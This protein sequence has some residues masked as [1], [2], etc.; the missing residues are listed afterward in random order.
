[1]S[2]SVQL[3][4][5]DD[6]VDNQHLLPRLHGIGLHL[7][8]VGAILLHVLGRLAGAWQL[9]PLADRHKGRAQPQGKGGPKEKA[10]GIEANNNV[11]LRGE[12]LLDVQLERVDQGLKQGGVCE[13]G[14]DVLEQDAGGGEVGELAQGGLELY[15]KIGEFGGGG[16]TGGGESSLG[17]IIALERGIGL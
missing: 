10:A 12:G 7:E 16:G 14:Q 2:C 4:S 9:A 17:G 8:E 15:F 5:R 13:D 1:M 6:V 3:T 11:G